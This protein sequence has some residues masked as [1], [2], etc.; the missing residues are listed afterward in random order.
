VALDEVTSLEF[1][2]HYTRAV[3][4]VN[5]PVVLD[6][7]ISLEFVSHYTRAVRIVSIGY[8]EIR[9]IINTFKASGKNTVTPMVIKP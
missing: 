3:R 2:S 1:V 4:L 6:E 8:S 7:A 5:S 9:P